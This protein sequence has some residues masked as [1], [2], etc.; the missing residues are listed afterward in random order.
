MYTNEVQSSG[1]LPTFGPSWVNFYGA[2][3]SYNIMSEHDDLN[4]GLGEGSAYRGRLLMSISTQIV[5][6]N[7]GKCQVIKE[8]LMRTGTLVSTLSGY[9]L[10]PSWPLILVLASCL[11]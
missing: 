4:V 1:I 9:L 3:R 5:K 10:S 7:I 11:I 6:E 2:P 8:K